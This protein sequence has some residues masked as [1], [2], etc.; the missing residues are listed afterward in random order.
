MKWEYRCLQIS[1]PYTT[2]PRDGSGA[3]G[4]IE[5]QLNKLGAEGWELVSVAPNGGS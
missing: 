3:T 1:A 5:Q 4:H 2:A